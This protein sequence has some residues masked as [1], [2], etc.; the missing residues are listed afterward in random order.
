MSSI[1]DPAFALK[2]KPNISDE[3]R[4]PTLA[5]LRARH[6]CGAVASSTFVIRDLEV[7]LAWREYKRGR[8]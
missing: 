3:D 1:H 4:R 8:A 7:E 6:D 2:R 5:W